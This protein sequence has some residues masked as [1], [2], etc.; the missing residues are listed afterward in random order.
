M[1]TEKKPIATLTFK[2]YKCL[3]LETKL[4]F[5]EKLTHSLSKETLLPIMVARA[6]QGMMSDLLEGGTLGELVGAQVEAAL[7][8]DEEM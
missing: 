1:D 6:A 7:R 2:F 8:M 4:D 3:G 5:D